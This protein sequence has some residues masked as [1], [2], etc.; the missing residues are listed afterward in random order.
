MKAQKTYLK[1]KSVFIVS[2]IVVGITIA[3]VYFTGIHYHRSVTSNLYW[4][5]I[6]ITC[7]LLIFLTYGLYKGLAIEDN[8]P[9]LEEARADSNFLDGS[10]LDAVPGSD[11]IGEME[12]PLYGILAWIGVTLL[13]I[14]LFIFLEVIFWFSIFLL[15]AMLYWVYFRALRLVFS[16]S[17]KT[18]GDFGNA[19]IYALGYTTLY[20]GWIFGIV[21]VADVFR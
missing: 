17:H 21:Y 18:R 9:T 15:L 16:I 13:F 11:I 10:L 3:T 7:S 19:F 5:L 14:V 20:T 2:L 4:S 8:F 1:G 6:G 12:N